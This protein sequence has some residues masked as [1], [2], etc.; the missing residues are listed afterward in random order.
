MLRGRNPDVAVDLRRASPTYGKSV[1]EELS[2]RNRKQLLV[3]TPTQSAPEIRAMKTRALMPAPLLSSASELYLIQ[4]AV[5]AVMVEQC[6]WRAV[7]KPEAIHRLERHA[8][9][10]GGF[11]K[12]HAEL[13]LGARR[14]RIAARG[15][16]IRRDRA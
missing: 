4:H 11:T 9:V 16:A 10:R 6:G 14:E 3:P 7:A 5:H 15:L 1:T 13:L 2:A 12:L 8:G